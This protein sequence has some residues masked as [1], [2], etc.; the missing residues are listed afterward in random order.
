MKP[1]TSLDAVQR[2][3]R[4]LEPIANRAAV[5][6]AST[7]STRAENLMYCLDNALAELN[8]AVEVYCGDF[9]RLEQEV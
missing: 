9:D 3:I 2:A 8:K 7:N 6:Y 4:Q 5:L 1:E